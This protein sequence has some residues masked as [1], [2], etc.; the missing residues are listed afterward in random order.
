MTAEDEPVPVV[1]NEV[2]LVT[3]AV[4]I[5]SVTVVVVEYVPVSFQEVP[6]I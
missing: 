3:L 2:P 5:P 1:F 4:T 6:E